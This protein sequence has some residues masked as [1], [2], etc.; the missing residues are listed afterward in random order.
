MLAVRDASLRS[1][2]KSSVRAYDRAG[3]LA[4]VV[5]S[6]EAE[7]R[8][9]QPAGKVSQ[10]VGKTGAVVAAVRGCSVEVPRSVDGQ[11]VGPLPP[12]CWVKL[13]MTCRFPPGSKHVARTIAPRYA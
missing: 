12:C 6:E 10:L 9:Q 8:I 7:Q 11:A 2:V 13:E 1:A 3:R 4:P 5:T